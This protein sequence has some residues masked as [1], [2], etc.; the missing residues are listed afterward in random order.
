MADVAQT[1]AVWLALAAMASAAYDIYTYEDRQTK[2]EYAHPGA[3]YIRNYRKVMRKAE[4][5]RRMKGEV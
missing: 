3:T 2:W 1:I 4:R 5:A